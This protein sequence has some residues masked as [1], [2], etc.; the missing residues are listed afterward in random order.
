MMHPGRVAART[1]QNGQ[2]T[3][4]PGP[5]AWTVFVL[6]VGLMLADY[7]SRQVLNVVFP[8]L[9]S[10]WALSDTELGSLSSIVAVMVGLL[11]FPLSMLADR[12]GR[13]RCL[14]LAAVI[15]SLA[16]LGCAVSASYEQMF[17]AR[18]V[19]G[20]GEA[21]YGSVGLAV[22]LSFFSIRLRATVAGVFMAG[23][24]FGSVLGVSIG[25]VVAEVFG[26]RWSF[27]VMGIFGLVVAVLYGAVVRERK[28]RYYV[29]RV[30]DPDRGGPGSLRTMLPKLFSSVSLVCVYIGSGL[31]LFVPFALLAWTPSFL[32]R[33]YEMSP[34]QAGLASGAFALLTGV[35]LIAGGMVADRVS[36]TLRARKWNVV[37]VSSLGS[38]VLLAVAFQ[39]PTGTAQLVVLSV[40]VLLSNAAASPAVSIVADLT[41]AALAATALATLTLAN[42][43]LGIAAGAAVTGVLADAVG[44]LNALR[45]VPFVAVLASAAF[46]IGKMRYGNAWS[47]A[48][49]EALPDAGPGRT[50]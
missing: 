44:L 21:A 40:G 13:V 12:W 31:Q 8:I 7:M 33:Y 16:T 11:S 10:E 39:L 14:V 28:A 37:I 27:A 47:R 46:M 9:K 2:D 38:L 36:R 4:V 48:N 1:E 42:N 22:L 50:R 15:W 25:G 20:V 19:L 34:A 5:Y 45:I 17:A 24:P 35:G 18:F 49:P 26:W 23:G 29:A 41:P 32:A 30:S 3:A 43:L 6:T